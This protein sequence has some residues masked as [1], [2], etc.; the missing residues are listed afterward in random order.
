MDFSTAPQ[1]PPTSPHYAGSG[2]L[3]VVEG[4]LA[5]LIAQPAAVLPD[6][7]AA[8]VLVH[9]E[10]GNAIGGVGAAGCAGHYQKLVRN[11]GPRH[12]HL[13]AVE[14]VAAAAAG[15]SHLNG[16]GA[17]GILGLGEG[18]RAD[19]LASCYCREKAALLVVVPGL[20]DEVRAEH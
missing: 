7:H 1:A 9:Q 19:L 3:N 14:G 6:G 2:H 15:G 20:Y 16:A 18:K 4:N 13:C 5:D 11:V 8:G 17:P 10:D 12:E